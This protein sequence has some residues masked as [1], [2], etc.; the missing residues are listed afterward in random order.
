VAQR[1]RRPNRQV[2]K[3]QRVAAYAV[4]IRDD[5]ILLSRLASRLSKK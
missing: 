3:V 4:I 1:E 2:R 5:H